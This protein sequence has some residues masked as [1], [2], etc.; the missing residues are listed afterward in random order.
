M[1]EIVI[2]DRRHHAGDKKQ[3]KPNQKMNTQTKNQIK[4]LL[5]VK[6]SN[7][8]KKGDSHP[9]VAAQFDVDAL[10]KMAM[11]QPKYTNQLLDEVIED[12]QKAGMALA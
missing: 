2:P 10:V 6:I 1:R 11:G 8:R 3:K 12:A 4:K 9:E 5:E 7:Y